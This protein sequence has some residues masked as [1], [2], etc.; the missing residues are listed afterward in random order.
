MT[1]RIARSLRLSPIAAALA[2]AACGGGGGYGTSTVTATETTPTTSATTPTTTPPAEQTSLRAYFLLDGKV[3]PVLRVV[4]K[5]R[6]VATAAFS[7]LVKGV[8]HEE[9]GIGL[10][11]EMPDV[12]GW[13]IDRSSNG[14]LT[15][16]TKPLADGALAQA[17]YT[18]TQFPTSRTVDVNGK[19]YTRADFEDHT[20]AILVELP[21]P[22]ETVT[23]PLRIAG[24]AN[25]FE[26]TFEYDLVGPDGKVIAHHV[27][28]ATSGSGTRGTFDVT[29][30]FT[31]AGG[32]AGRLIVYERSAENGRRTHVVEIPITFGT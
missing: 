5:T 22:F 23:S 27:V 8:S 2:L 4:P 15:L 7:E 16:S 21:L 25:T 28:T 12:Q 31:V 13:T 26:A 3:Q 11:S 20:P 19:R 29:Q 18:L 24:S 30:P 9:A 32:S 10:T 6:A 1:G 14:I 17:V